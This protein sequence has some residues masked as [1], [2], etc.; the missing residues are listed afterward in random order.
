MIVDLNRFSGIGANELGIPGILYNQ[1]NQVID[2]AI[3]MAAYLDYLGTFAA[4][5]VLGWYN[6]CTQNTTSYTKIAYYP[7][8]SGGNFSIYPG[9]AL[10]I[11]VPADVTIP[12]KFGQGY[13][14]HLICTETAAKYCEWSGQ[15]EFDYLEG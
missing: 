9:M 1:N 15:E 14:K 8:W 3:A 11:T 4:G 5:T 7:F 13:K 2:N 12:L 10:R 6:P